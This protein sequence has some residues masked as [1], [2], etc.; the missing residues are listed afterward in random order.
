MMKIHV[1]LNPKAKNGDHIYAE[2]IIRKKFKHFLTDVSITTHPKHATEIAYNVSRKK[3]DTLVVV[4]GD[5]TINEAINGIA[6]TDTA[7]GIIP[8]GTANDLASFYNIP[9]D[10][11][12]ACDVILD[13]NLYQTDL[14]RVNGWY[15]IT[16]GGIG[17]PAQVAKIANTIKCRDKGG[18]LL[19]KILGSNL[20]ILSLIWA[21]RRK[22]IYRNFL[23][24]QSNGNSQK[25][26]TIFFMVNNQPFLGKNFLVSPGANNHDGLFNVCLAENSKNFLKI[27]NVLVKTLY[28]GHIT[29]PLVKTWSAKELCITAENPAAFLGDGETMPEGLKFEISIVPRALNIIAPGSGNQSKKKL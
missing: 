16:A 28:G 11:S 6:G 24:I 13:R 14:I 1:I 5:G 26:D 23:E 10:F 2:S 15:Y 7:L 19:S 27:L 8:T 12:K 3:I 9:G 17:L 22:C 20:Y 18:K 29:S 4:G 21:V 25:I